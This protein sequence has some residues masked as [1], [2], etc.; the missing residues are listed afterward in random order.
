M[1][2]SAIQ[3]EVQCYPKLIAVNATAA[4]NEG[5]CSYPGRS[6]RY[7]PDKRRERIATGVTHVGRHG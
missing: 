7:A 1:D 5:H 4:R 2:D 6:A 3:E